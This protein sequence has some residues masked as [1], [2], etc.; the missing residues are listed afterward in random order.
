MKAAV[1]AAAAVVARLEVKWRGSRRC[2]RRAGSGTLPAAWREGDW[3]WWL[4]AWAGVAA[5]RPGLGFLSSLGL[6][7]PSRGLGQPRAAAGARRRRAATDTNFIS[8]RGVGGRARRCPDLI[9]YRVPRRPYP[10]R[11]RTGWLTA[12]VD[13]FPATTPWA[14][15]APWPRGCSPTC[16][17]SRSCLGPAGSR[18]EALRRSSGTSAA[19]AGRRRS[20]VGGTGGRVTNSPLATCGIKLWG[21]PGAEARGRVAARR[22]DEP[23]GCKKRFPAWSS[24][25]HTKQSSPCVL[26]RPYPPGDSTRFALSSSNILRGLNYTLVLNSDQCFLEH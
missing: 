13:S 26:C 14:L 15:P 21:S 4:S 16:Q 20:L 11:A 17:I 2:W 5:R 22:R 1:A 6:G 8:R 18:R 23:T 3:G 25:G 10:G 12:G 19:C 24:P 7:T 9:D